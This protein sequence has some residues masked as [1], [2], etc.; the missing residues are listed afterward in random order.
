MRGLTL[1][2]KRVLDMVGACLL[3]VITSP[4]WLAIAWAIHRDSPGPVFF[5]QTRIGRHGR[6]FVIYKFRTMRTGS[7]REWRAPRPEDFDGY[8]FQERGD[9]RIT[10]VGQFL[11][12][13][14]LDELP[15]LL[16][17][18]KGEMGLVGPRPEIPEMVAL[19]TPEMHRRHQFRPGMTGLAQVSGRG[20]LATAEILLYDLIYCD[21]WSLG[22]DLK[23]LLLT[24]MQVLGG[25]GAR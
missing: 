9:T 15:Q 3:L 23:I 18:L 2:L 21:D 8:V 20:E 12:R 22:L 25:Q 11:R 10:S 24:V 17:V 13:T 6:P 14:S 7:E 4:L 5:R 19:Y 1:G 16:N